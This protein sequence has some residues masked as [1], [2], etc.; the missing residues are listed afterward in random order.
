VV[1]VGGVLPPSPPVPGLERATSLGEVLDDLSS[2]LDRRGEGG[3]A[4]RPAVVVAVANPRKADLPRLRQLMQQGA[5]RQ[6]HTLITGTGSSDPL[7]DSGEDGERP[8]R[9]EVGAEGGILSVEP[10]ELAWRVSGGG[11]FR[12][13]HDGAAELLTLLSAARTEGDH[14]RRGRFANAAFDVPPPLPA[15]SPGPLDVQALGGWCVRRGD[16]DLTEDLDERASQLAAFLVL[17]P[18]GATV[19]EVDQALFDGSGPGDADGPGERL[20]AVVRDLASALGCG[21]ADLRTGGTSGPLRLPPAEVDL[22]E[23]QRSLARAAAEATAADRA[24]R[25]DTAVDLYTGELLAGCTWLWPQGPRDDLRGRVVDVLV[26]LADGRWAV[27]NVEGASRALE[28]AV[29][30][31]PYAEQ[32]YRR[33]M[34]LAARRDRLEEVEKVFEQLKERLALWGLEP[35]PETLKLRSELLAG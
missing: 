3:S 35:T 11:L 26:W 4:E 15:D 29:V 24:T 18:Q 31:D 12:A 8:A 14:Y 21:V 25:F 16:R 23:L 22:W 30:V 20:E 28:R 13:S 6:I 19:E 5:S 17:H 1:A 7:A 32:L 33:Q 9:I 2:E 10:E 27:G 34:R